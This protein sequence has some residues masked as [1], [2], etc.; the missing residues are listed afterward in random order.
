LKRTRKKPEKVSLVNNQKNSTSSSENEINE[1]QQIKKA[2]K[3]ISK[4]LAK[5]QAIK[6]KEKPIESSEKMKLNDN[7]VSCNKSIHRYVSMV[8]LENP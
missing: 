8:V 2:S 7:V 4:K 1:S 6:P 5:Q 3:Q